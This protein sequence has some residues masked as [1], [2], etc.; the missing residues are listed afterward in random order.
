M[1]NKKPY[2]RIYY[3]FRLQ[4]KLRDLVERMNGINVRQGG[5]ILCLE[6]YQKHCICL[7][8]IESESTNSVG[9]ENEY[10]L[11]MNGFDENDSIK[12]NG[13]KSDDNK[14]NNN[15]GIF[16]FNGNSGCNFKLNDDNGADI[17]VIGKEFKLN[18][19]CRDDHNLGDDSDDEEPITFYSTLIVPPAS[20]LLKYIRAERMN[21]GNLGP[22]IKS[23]MKRLDMIHNLNV[24]DWLTL[25]DDVDNSL[26]DS[27][28][29]DS[30]DDDNASA[31]MTP[32]Q[33]PSKDTANANRPKTTNAKK[34]QNGDAPTMNGSF[35]HNTVNSP[36]ST[37][38]ATVPT[39]SGEKVVTKYYSLFG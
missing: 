37:S 35:A 32:V 21:D 23:L 15:N 7:V 33:P 9:I 29:V 10:T 12:I 13:Y 36:P 22:K 14:E 25:L 38:T 16:Q 20:L 26:S 39:S 3:E 11:N 18:G 31:I 28:S 27:I 1:N 6:C 17:K 2:P 30:F 19:D 5:K 34:L 24:D 4:Q 8:E